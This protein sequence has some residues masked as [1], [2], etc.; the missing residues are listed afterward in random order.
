MLTLGSE[1]YQL[2]DRD[3]QTVQLEEL[4]LTGSVSWALAQNTLAVFTQAL[5][6]DRVYY[7]GA[8]TAQVDSGAAAA[9]LTSLQLQVTPAGGGIPVVVWRKAGDELGSRTSNLWG[10]TAYPRVILPRGGTLSLLGVRSDT[11]AVGT[12]SWSVMGFMI[13]PGSIARGS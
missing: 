9:R 11:T 8:F 5:P 4:N 7:L 6:L 13:P 2:T 10:D 3:L 1:L 12:V